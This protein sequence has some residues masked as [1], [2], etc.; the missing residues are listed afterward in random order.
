MKEKSL[1]KLCI[2]N[3][4]YYSYHGVRSEE[5]TLGG[6]YEVDLEM[7]YDAREAIINDNVANA[8]NYEEALFC[9]TEVISGDNYHLIETIASEILDMVL[10]RFPECKKAT[11]RL[12]KM[13]VPMKRVIGCIEVEQSVIR[14]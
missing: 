6:K 5:R 7:Y 13:S 4:E 10:D 14:K 8:L 1:T 3:A 9:V 2:Q 11:V 12:R